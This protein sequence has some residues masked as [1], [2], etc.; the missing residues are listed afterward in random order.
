MSFFLTRNFKYNPFIGDT[1]K[2]KKQQRSKR[3]AVKL[4]N[5]KIYVE[6]YNSNHN[7]APADADVFLVVI[8][9][10]RL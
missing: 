10:K 8:T 3:F 6:S 1:K 4:L 7:D 9:N 2:Q 5:Y